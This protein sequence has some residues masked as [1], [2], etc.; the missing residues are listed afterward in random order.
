[1]QRVAQS[2]AVAADV[3]QSAMGD[4]GRYLVAAGVALSTFGAASANL[5]VGPR[6][7]FAMA[8]DGLLPGRVGR[9]HAKAQTPANAI[10]T[11]AVW[12]MVMVHVAF[13]I[14]PV[15]PK[16]GTRLVRDAFDTLT[17]FAILG[18][19]IFYAMSV[20]AVFVLR[21]KM[22]DAPR[23]YR[24]WG[25]PFTPILFLLAF[26]A[27]QVSLLIKRPIESLAGFVLIGVGAIYYAWAVRQPA[28]RRAGGS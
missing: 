25:Y 16:T 9:V 5:I 15:D 18:S 17:D 22:P 13:S 1:M 7:I 21:R 27:L 19:S 2:D 26:L 3:F 4:V 8:R 28:A 24:T 11:Q 14:A 20:A 23:S 6:I 10:V 12:A